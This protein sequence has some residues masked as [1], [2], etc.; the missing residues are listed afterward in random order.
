MVDVGA[1]GSHSRQVASVNL[2]AEGRVDGSHRKGA[3]RLGRGWIGDAVDGHGECLGGDVLGGG[4][5]VAEGYGVVYG[6]VGT[7]GG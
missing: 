5:E 3:G 4:V 1:S 7:S 6:G 2:P